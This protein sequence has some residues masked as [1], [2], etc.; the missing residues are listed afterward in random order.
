[1]LK[2]GQVVKAQVLA[3][4]TEKRIIRLS[5]KQTRSNRPR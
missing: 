1:V 4:D 5:M 2:A 3:L